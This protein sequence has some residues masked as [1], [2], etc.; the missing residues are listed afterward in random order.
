MILKSMIFFVNVIFSWTFLLTSFHPLTYSKL[1]KYWRILKYVYKLYI[2]WIK[3]FIDFMT[4]R[5]TC[6]WHF[7]SHF[8]VNFYIQCVNNM[9]QN[10]ATYEVNINIFYYKHYKN[11]INRQTDMHIKYDMLPTPTLKASFGLSPMSYILQIPFR[12]TFYN[13]ISCTTST[14]TSD[15][16]TFFFFLGNIQL[17]EAHIERILLTLLPTTATTKEVLCLYHVDMQS[18]WFLCE[19]RRTWYIP[20]IQNDDPC[21]EWLAEHNG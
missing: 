7:V 1:I 21:D 2:W 8:C 6:S 4:F 20:R 9:N 10:V 11:I 5:Y 17:L 3:V 16:M 15:H 18:T 12:T 14:T 13:Y 19:T